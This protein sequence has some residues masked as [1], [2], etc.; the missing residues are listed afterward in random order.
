MKNAFF[1]RTTSA[2]LCA[3]VL[4]ATSLVGGSAMAAPAATAST[5][6]DFPA[7]DGQLMSYVVNVKAA[8]ANKTRTAVAAIKAAGGVA[9]Q[10]WPEIGV[11]VVQSDRANFRSN[12]MK[13]GHSAIESVGATR[14]ITVAEGTP[15]EL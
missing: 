13:L 5:P 7:A 15:E 2:A 4:A 14:T 3:V 6:I 8:N 1:R 12:V 10:E 11:V 9:V